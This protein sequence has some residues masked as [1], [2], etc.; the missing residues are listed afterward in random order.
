M[1]KFNFSAYEY[2]L[3][4]NYRE[5]HKDNNDLSDW[6][7]HIKLVLYLMKNGKSFQSATTTAQNKIPLKQ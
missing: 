7:E 5:H 1:I 4:D 2:L 6:V 3:I